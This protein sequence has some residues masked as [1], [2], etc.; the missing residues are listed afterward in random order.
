MAILVSNECYFSLERQEY[1]Q[2]VQNYNSYRHTN[3]HRQAH[4]VTHKNGNIHPLE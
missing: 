2:T 3:T 1:F 4:T